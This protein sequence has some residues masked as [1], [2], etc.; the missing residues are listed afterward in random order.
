MKRLK[1]NVQSFN[2]DVEANDGY[3]YTNNAPYSSVVANERLT[4]ATISSI[5]NGVLTLIDIGCGD[6]TYTNDIG[7]VLKKVK[8]SA[9]DPASKAVKLAAKKYKKVNFFVSNILDRKTFAKKTGHYDAGVIRGVLHHLNDPELAV[10]NSL[11]LAKK[12]IIIEPNGNNPVLKFIEK[13]SKY[14]IEHE[15]RSFTEKQLRD[16]CIKAGGKINSVSYV[17][18]VPFFFP[19]IPARIIHFFQPL[20]EKIPVI[21]YFLSAQIIILCERK[22][23]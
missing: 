19:E 18:F 3:F 20:L 2:R 11:A 12:L 22:N 16:F 15:E 21:N 8:I 6:G 5:E 1:K 10:R 9:T 13:N 23:S 7:T 17:G 14:H 4:E